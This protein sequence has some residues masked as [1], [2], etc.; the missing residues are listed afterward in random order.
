MVGDGSWW[1]DKALVSK[2]FA[3]EILNM[4]TENDCLRYIKKNWSEIVLSSW[5]LTAFQVATPLVITIPIPA[6]TSTSTAASSDANIV[7]LYS[8]TIV[9]CHW[10][11]Q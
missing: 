8:A 10:D 6:P 7:E 4:N 11:Y 9:E 3:D 5:L 2:L 1:A